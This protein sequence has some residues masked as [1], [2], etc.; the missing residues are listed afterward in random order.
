MKR[1]AVFLVLMATVVVSVIPAQTAEFRGYTSKLWSAQDGLVDQN[2]QAFAL[3]PHGRLWIGTRSGLLSFDGATFTSYGQSAA[4]SALGRGVNC[5]LAEKDG[6]L[7]IGTE[8]GGLLHLQNSKFQSYAVA[9]RP[10]NEFVRTVFQDREGTIWVGADQGL[11]RVTGRA[12]KRVDGVGGAPAIFVRAIAE[13]RSGNVWVGGNKLL[14]FTHGLYV[15]EVSKPAGISQDL[16]YSLLT[17]R[18]GTLWVGALSGLYQISSRDRPRRFQGIS[19]PVTVMMENSHGDLWVG[20]AGHGITLI[21]RGAVLRV[22]YGSLPSRTVTAV[23]EDREGDI[24]IGTRAGMLQLTRTPVRL[25]PIPGGMDSEFETLYR[26]LDGSIWM[27]ASSHLFHIRNGVATVWRFQGMPHLRVRTLLRDRQGNLWIGTE[28]QGLLCIGQHG[29]RRYTV[30]MGVIN[31]FIRV[32]LQGRDGSIWV[33]TDGGVTHITPRGTENFDT[34]NG[35]AYS[36]IT[37]LLEARNGDIW[38]GT[39]RGLSHLSGKEYIQDV[40]T[41]TLRQDQLWSILQDATGEIWFGTSSGLYG[42]GAGKLVHLTTAEGLA[43]NIIYDILEDDKGDIWLS[44]PNSI[45]RLPVSDLDAFACKDAGRV[46]LTLFLDSHDLG[47]ASLYGG[48][49]PEGAVAPDGD[50]WFPAS[51]GALHVVA[52]RIVPET[53]FPVVIDQILS[54]GRSLS[55]DRK[56]VLQPGNGQLQITYGAVRLRSQEAIRYRYRMEGL[57]PWSDASTRRTAYYTQLPAGRYHFEVQASAIDNSRAVAEATVEIVQR[58]HFYAT[59]WFATCCLLL[60]LSFVF[61]GYRL[62]LR[63]MRLRFQ[64]VAEERARLAREMHDT[65]IQ[66]CIGV[67]SLLEA[68]LGVDDAEEPLRLQL[69]NYANEQARNTIESARE[70]VWA[71]RNPTTGSTDIG[72]LCA[73]LARKFESEHGIPIVCRVFGTQFGLGDVQTHELIM[74]LREALANAVTHSD[75]RRIVLAVDFSE[76]HATITIE[77]DGTGFDPEVGMGTEGHYGLIGMRERVKLVGGQLSIVSHRGQGTAVTIVVPRK[78]PA[79]ERKTPYA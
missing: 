49:Q 32:I 19:V 21:R 59:L 14:E 61:W 53:G 35:L 26:D 79:Q 10:A 76:S 16:V 56:V 62:R 45:S 6:S 39:S 7:W 78:A 23:L 57:E 27:T 25:V 11:F 77:D 12:L 20:T 2:V 17:T 69:L 42:F 70:A 73:D 43:S 64:A 33:G 50:V 63:Q 65:V 24:W 46:D 58:P 15:R 18:D 13:D 68:A 52:S 3:T 31:G 72:S 29:S 37:S 28:G 51:G 41:E 5:L 60:L 55:P 38:I 34:P 1:I 75:A 66:G 67:S 30:P 71:L 74:T 4:S 9:G 36:S 40:A 22:G 47:S 54:N 48:L 8:G 44:G